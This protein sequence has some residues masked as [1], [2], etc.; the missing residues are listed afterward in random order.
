MYI[1]ISPY[2]KDKLNVTKYAAYLI[3]QLSC[4]HAW[5]CSENLCLDKESETYTRKIFPLIYRKLNI[6]ESN[7]VV[8]IKF[9][10]FENVH[11]FTVPTH[12]SKIITPLLL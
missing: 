5:K 2:E 7:L 4:W 9:N 6:I 8:L 1:M 3:P 10:G 11:Q 12:L